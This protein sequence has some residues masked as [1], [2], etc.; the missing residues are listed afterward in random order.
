VQDKGNGD[1]VGGHE[2]CDNDTQDCVESGGAANIDES[3]KEGYSSS[4]KNG[5]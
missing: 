1:A 4:D 3:K 2:T 5:V